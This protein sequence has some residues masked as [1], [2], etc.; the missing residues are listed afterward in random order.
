MN[1]SLLKLSFLLAVFFC[2]ILWAY[3]SGQ[4]KYV[5]EV[6]SFSEKI[7]IPIAHT[8]YSG[9]AEWEDE[10]SVRITFS[11]RS[12]AESEKRKF[13]SCLGYIE[14]ENA[15]CYLLESPEGLIVEKATFIEPFVD[16]V[17]L[18]LLEY[19]WKS[20]VPP[21]ISEEMKELIPWESET[22]LRELEAW[23]RDVRTVKTKDY[24]LWS[25]E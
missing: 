7:P 10:K 21:G 15:V 8:V 5:F 11:P 14:T 24:L 9:S 12:I 3:Y 18:S 16:A 13:I 1:K 25:Q 4:D 6:V 20:H 2:L 17:R 22:T 19:R 23:N